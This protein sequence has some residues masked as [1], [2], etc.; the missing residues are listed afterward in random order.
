MTKI[1]VS[2]K[3]KPEDLL[4][5]LETKLMECT[6]AV[7]FGINSIDN[8]KYLPDNLK[9]DDKSIFK[10]YP[11][12]KLDLEK[13]KHN[14]KEWILKK[15]F[16]DLII[17]LTELL[18]SF[19]SIIDIEKKINNK[20]KSTIN[21]FIDLVFEPNFSNSKKPFPSLIN[22]IE[23]V[24][25]KSLDYKLEIQSINKI[26]RCLEHRNGIVRPTDFNVENGI[27]LRWYYYEVFIDDNGKERPIR[28]SEMINNKTNIT[29]KEVPKK[30]FFEENE[31]IKI[32]FAEFNEL[33]H[34]CQ[35]FGKKLLKDY[36]IKNH[37][38]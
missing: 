23:K 38:K 14:F 10:Y 3:L 36:L 2:L 9:T 18:I 1:K 8:I 31:Q 27:E 20:G 21:E 17:A 28:K 30:V 29:L 32:S 35:I 15:G 33:A 34:F 5:T 4:I 12:G 16:G 19:S 13:S 25:G 11:I 26:R 24:I 7:F 6:N 37:N 22:K